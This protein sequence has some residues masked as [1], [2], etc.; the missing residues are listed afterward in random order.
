MT[1]LFEIK[2]I[3]FEIKDLD[4][5]SR[6]V[7][8]YVSAFGNVDSHND[9]MQKGAYAKTIK[10]NKSRIKF[11][12]N[13]NSQEFPV[14]VLEEIDEDDFGLKTVSKIIN[15]TKGNDLLECYATGAIN[16]HSV[17]F[18]TINK[19][20]GNDGVRVITEAQ[21]LEYS[22]VLW[23]SNANTP[24]LGMKKLGDVDQLNELQKRSQN[25]HKL[26]TKGNLSDETCQQLALEHVLVNKAMTDIILSLKG[27]TEPGINPTQL[28]NIEPIQVT[29]LFAAFKS[30]IK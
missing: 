20:S 7:V 29:D 11:L 25:L 2:S 30:Q 4:T 19:K 27:N 26:L 15:T 8:K 28:V 9:V 14:G 10:E 17:G 3:P 24:L 22:A 5:S 13:H 12:W 6:R 18:Y 16:E 1:T 21:L 23:G